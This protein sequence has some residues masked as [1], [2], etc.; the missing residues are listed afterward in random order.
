MAQLKP[1]DKAAWQPQLNEE[2][3]AWRWFKLS[4]LSSG[5]A[6]QNAAAVALH[7]V[8]ELALRSEPHRQVVLAALGEG[9]QP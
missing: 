7:P 1:E 8:V 6:A 4:E 5:S 9:T 3:S 2:H